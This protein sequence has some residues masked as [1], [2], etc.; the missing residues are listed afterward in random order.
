MVPENSPREI[1]ERVVLIQRQAMDALG[2]FTP[3]ELANKSGL[4]P[5]T[6]SRILTGKTK[7]I[8]DETACRLIETIYK[9]NVEEGYTAKDCIQLLVE[10]LEF[11]WCHCAH[12][13]R[14]VEPF[15]QTITE[16]DILRWNILIRQRLFRHTLPPGHC[17]HQFVASGDAQRNLEQLARFADSWSVKHDFNFQDKIEIE[18]GHHLSVIEAVI[19]Q[20]IE[21]NLYLPLKE[22]FCKM[23]YALHLCGQFKLVLDVSQWL[24]DKSVEHEDLPMNLRAKVMLAWTLTSS[25]NE[26]NYDRAAKLIQNSCESIN[27]IGNLQSLKLDDMDVIAI[28]SELIL[29]LPLRIQMNGGR[30]L[31]TKQFTKISSQARTL[32]GEIEHLHVCPE[33]LKIRYQ[34]P[35]EYQTG[36]YFFLK[37]D[38]DNALSHFRSVSRQAD[39][40]GWQRI[41]IAS[42]SWLASINIKLNNPEECKQYLE[43]MGQYPRQKRRELKARIREEL[44]SNHN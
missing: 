32:L 10:V 9:Q 11:S 43:Q 20:G 14:E 29:R 30:K 38:Y 44:E 26:G 37:N 36:I 15:Q 18:I 17:L 27:Q 33:N 35:L 8:G 31:S 24:L 41:S 4:H 28:L 5:A 2:F 21:Q 39:L 16:G 6:V 3:R 34:I 22:V 42:Y 12:I 19:R 1:A 23:Q 7:R 40:I 25:K 13:Y